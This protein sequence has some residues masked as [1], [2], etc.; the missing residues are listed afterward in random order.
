MKQGY[1][2]KFKF[3]NKSKLELTN[4]LLNSNKFWQFKSVLFRLTTKLKL[5]SDIENV[6]YLNWLIPKE[7]IENLLPSNVKIEEHNGLVLLTVLTYKHGNFAPAILGRLRVFF[8][9]PYQSNWRLYSSYPWENRDSSEGTVLFIKNILSSFIYTIGSRIMSN[10]LQ[11]Q[12]AKIFNFKKNDNSYFVDINPGEAN[13]PRLK[14]ECKEESNWNF[15]DRYS[16]IFQNRTN[17]LKAICFQEYALTELPINN[18]LCRGRIKLEFDENEIKPLNLVSLEGTQF[19]QWI[20]GAP[21]FGFVIPHVKFTSLG[22]T[23]IKDGN[24]VYSQ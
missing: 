16:E 19:Q 6:I 3:Y 23:I 24:T 5:R 14:F 9:S 7:R 4:S 2:H 13:F 15:E 11:S 10:V 20:D 18:W 21:F 17:L 12:C 1:T 22:E 8:G